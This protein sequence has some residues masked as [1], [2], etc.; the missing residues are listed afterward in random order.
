VIAGLVGFML[1]SSIATAGS[2]GPIGVEKPELSAVFTLL[3]GAGF[4]SVS[5][6]SVT[7]SG[8]DNELFE[9]AQTQQN[10]ASGFLGL[11]AGGE[12]A[13]SVPGFFMQAGLEYTAFQ[14]S[15]VKGLNSVG[16]EPTTL[17]IYNYQYS[18]QSQQILAVAK[19]FGTVTERYH[20]YVSVGLGAGFNNSKSF[21]VTT[22]ETESLNVAPL[23]RNNVQTSFSYS[24]GLGVDADVNEHLRIGLG[25]RFTDLGASSLGSGT[26]SVND[27]H[28]NSYSVPTGFTLSTGDLYL[29]QVVA[30]ISYIL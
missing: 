16:I 18:I 23:F 8:T 7:F 20:P 10:S 27:F 15:T 26:V 28:L 24:A 11:F 13:L 5:H 6:P 3:G 12:Y 2:Q 29:N 19:V 1:G 9:Y 30:Q 4:F 22:A 17:T 14:N 21:Q 25:Y